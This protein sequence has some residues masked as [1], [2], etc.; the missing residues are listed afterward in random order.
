MRQ[1]GLNNP[2]SRFILFAI[3]ITGTISIHSADFDQDIAPI[4]VRSCVECHNGFD[5]KGKLNLSQRNSALKGGKS[6][7]LIL[8]GKPEESLL[9]NKIKNDDIEGEDDMIVNILHNY[10]S[11]IPESYIKFEQYSEIP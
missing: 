4:F 9:W 3:G 6:G 8:P 5:L 2:F 11:R 10:F 7:T 1:Y